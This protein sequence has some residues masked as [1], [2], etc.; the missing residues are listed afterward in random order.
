M[1]LKNS[2]A[3]TKIPKLL[4]LKLKDK[5]ISQIYKRFERKLSLNE[6]FI[7]AVSGGPDSLALAFL[8]KVYS[9]KKKIISKYFIVDHKLRSE[10]TE[11]A[12]LVKKTLKK[13]KINAEILTWRQKQKKNS[14]STARKKRYDLLFSQCKKHKINN[15]ILGHHLDDL[16]ENFFIRILRGSGLK[17]IVSLDHKTNI[18]KVNLFRPLLSFYKKE[19][20]YIASNV[21][22]FYI[23]DPSNK[24]EKY[25]RIKVR[26]LLKKLHE[27][28]LDKKKF[29]LTI[30]NLKNSNELIDYYVNENIK[31]NTFYNKEQNQVILNNSFFQQ[32]HE[33]IFRSLS[34]SLKMISG[35]FYS[36][37]GK[38]IDKLIEFLKKGRITKI[39]L[40]GCII[41]KINQTVILSK[42]N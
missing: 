10:S 21:F 9:I 5:K 29:E 11:E 34:G 37:R 20:L 6:S 8:S 14:Q 22:N 1:S 4:K 31:K 18:K 28:G 17:G 7:V 42:E 24:E 41:E 39:T 36:A 26:N 40:G 27:Y 2:S 35:N 3:K 32:P 30:K 33:I 15:I 13:F 38:K 19:L 25:Q 16:F 12:K 23:N